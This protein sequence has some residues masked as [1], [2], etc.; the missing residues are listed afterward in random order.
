MKGENVAA[1]DNFTQ[2]GKGE[3]LIFGRRF[4]P[5][6]RQDVHPQRVPDQ[7]NRPAN[8]AKANDAQRQARQLKLRSLPKRKVAAL[9]PLALFYGPPMQA[10]M[11]SKFQKQC[12]GELRDGLGAVFRDIGNRNIAGPGGR[13]INDVIPRR[14]NCNKAETGAPAIISSVSAALLAMTISASAIRAGI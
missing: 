6:S 12:D 13:D 7:T 9:A 14:R 10:D 1:F 8:P 3:R 4:T 2:I 11:V 5:A